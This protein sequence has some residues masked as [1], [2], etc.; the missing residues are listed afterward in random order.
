MKFLADTGIS[1]KTVEFLRSSG[2]DALHVLEQQLGRL[3]DPLI[4]E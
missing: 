2:Y 4:V 1:P 3:P